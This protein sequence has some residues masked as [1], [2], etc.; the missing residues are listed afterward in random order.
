MPLLLHCL[1][2]DAPAAAGYAAAIMLLMLS[3]CHAADAMPLMLLRRH[4]DI[5]RCCHDF[6][7]RFR[8]MLAYFHTM[9]PLPLMPCR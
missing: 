5:S 1:M 9:L 8:H 6:Y 7:F 3:R 4:A 2:L